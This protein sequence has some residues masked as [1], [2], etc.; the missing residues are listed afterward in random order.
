VNGADGLRPGST[1]TYT[2]TA[3]N[4]GG[5]DFTAQN[6]ARVFDSLTGVLADAS[7]NDDAVV[8]TP[9]GTLV[10]APA[11]DL[12]SWSGPLARNT[13]VT[14][15]YSVTIRPFTDAPAPTGVLRNVAWVPVDPNDATVPAC[16]QAPGGSLDPTTSQPC[17]VT[18][19]DRPVLRL[20]KTVAAPDLPGRV[21]SIVHYTIT[22]TNTGAAPFGGA[23]PAEIRDD[24]A[25]LADDATYLGDAAV[26]P[27]VG[28]LYHDTAGG[29]NWLRWSGPLGV[30][31]TLTF[32]Y[33]ARLTGA[34]DAVVANV[35]WNPVDSSDMDVP[36][37]A[38]S[39]DPTSQAVCSVTAFT[40][41]MLKLTKTHA[42]PPAAAGDTVTYTVTATNTSS[43]GYTSTN[44]AIVV[45]DLS[46][47]LDDA[48][49]NADATATIS[50][51]GDVSGGLT[52]DAAANRLV[53]RGALSPGATVTVSFTVTLT[54]Y[55]NG[56]LGNIAWE[57]ADPSAPT[58]PASC[59][60]GGVAATGEQCAADVST[61]PLARVTKRADW[62]GAPTAP[63]PGDT[64]TY[65]VTI[66]NIGGSPFTAAN[67]LDDLSGVVDQAAGAFDPASITINGKY[68][69]HSRPGPWT[70]P[71]VDGVGALDPATWIGSWS[72]P[73]AAKASTTL[74]YE[75]TLGAVE[76]SDA[77]NVVWVPGVPTGKTP[78]A[79]DV[80]SGGIDTP[81]GLPCAAVK[82]DRPGLRLDK[83]AGQWRDNGDGTKTLV[84]VDPSTLGP[85]AIVHFSTR[86]ENT[87]SGDFTEAN[88]ALLVEDMRSLS[89]GGSPV[90]SSLAVQPRDAQGQPIDC[91]Q[92]GKAQ[93]CGAIDRSAAP[94]MT[95]TGAIGQGASVTIAFDYRLDAG[96]IATAFNRVYEPKNPNSPFAVPAC[97]DGSSPVG[98]DY[99]GQ[100]SVT[101]EPCSIVH[102]QR[103]V[104]LLAK[105]AAPAQGSQTPLRAG[106]QVKYTLTIAN[107]TATDAAEAVIH[108][109]LTGVLTGATFTLAGASAQL[110][111]SPVTDV[112][113]GLAYDSATKQVTWT[114]AVP[115]GRTVTLTYATTLSGDGNGHMR[116]VAWQPD[117]P[118]DAAP[119]PPACVDTLPVDGFDDGTNE[120]CAVAEAGQAVLRVDKSVQAP[121]FPSPGSGLTYQVTVTNTGDTAFT[122]G[123]PAAIVDDLSDVLES[124]TWKGNL[125]VHPAAAPAPAFDP[126]TRAITWSGPLAARQ[127]VVIAYTAVAHGGGDGVLRNVAWAPLDPANP[128]A[129]PACNPAGPGSVRCAVT[130]VRRAVL[131][132]AKTVDA[133]DVPVNGSTITYTVTAGSSGALPFTAANPAVVVDD[134]SDILAGGVFDPTQ[135]KATVDGS[136]DVTGGLSY[137]APYLRWRGPL[138]TGQKV[139]ITFPIRL[140]GAGSGGTIRNVAWAPV[141]PATPGGP[142][143]PAC[144]G[145][146]SFDPATGEACA[147]NTLPRA[148]MSIAKA[149]SR[150]PAQARPGGKVEYTLTLTNAGDAD[151][152]AAHPAV[153]VDDLSGV[154]G[155]ATFALADAR[156]EP[157]GQGTLTWDPATALLTWTGP[158]ARG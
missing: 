135:A 49:Y 45:D 65:T 131:D 100:D 129:P 80:V 142:P 116:N 90:A 101:A 59:P 29:R 109:D 55:G 92:V 152:D 89:L 71:D 21:G 154:L 34:G 117:N 36:A 77:R 19:T 14:I 146:A 155:G 32:T 11:T 107:R 24:L 23:Y 91:T 15:T 2:V 97:S 76:A 137:A 12:L 115:A 73:L 30:N 114:G 134:L 58:P 98:T 44:P 140:A 94:L 82:L 84:P 38:A 53:W 64:I 136:T 150:E 157:P 128:G 158:L 56:T 28:S 113:A 33:S 133:P 85:G 110:D 105:T 39:P 63:V 25:G 122:A 70:D 20:R 147:V 9:D 95:W 104:L 18:L 103:P 62:A 50:T 125:T 111:T 4:L 148:L 61:R 144:P 93:Y 31:E 79:C 41:P 26:S 102:I 66:T 121:A 99:S 17:A 88:P 52:W 120:P 78:P 22:A 138:A 130:E 35:A 123:A 42:P 47:V 68:Q 118:A 69:D 132:I 6:P 151:Y 96:G 149:V 156:T 87:G 145:P 126:A 141:N 54:Q 48:T 74:T 46:D 83:Q 51:P 108:D 67:F 40:R 81:S 112:T 27:D 127:S 119:A 57:P 1:V 10:W 8:S 75:V 3:T 7:Y 86:A 43:T 5:E 153:V 124:A 106:D 143:P 60:A 139:E 16:D 37:C 13:S 72:G